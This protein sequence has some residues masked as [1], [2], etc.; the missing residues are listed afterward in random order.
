MAVDG[1]L[2]GHRGGKREESRFSLSVE[3]NAERGTVEPVFAR[4][5]SQARTE[6]GKKSC[7][8]T[9]QLT[10]SSRIDNYNTRVINT[11]LC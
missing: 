4:P 2:C 6:T 10:T 3:N 7:F 9:V 11:L 5:N 8:P 1:I